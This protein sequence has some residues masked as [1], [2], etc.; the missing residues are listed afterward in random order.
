MHKASTF[1]SNYPFLNLPKCHI[2]K[3]LSLPLIKYEFPSFELGHEPVDIYLAWVPGSGC[4]SQV[5]M[6][7]DSSRGVPK[8]ENVHLH[9]LRNHFI[10]V[11]ISPIGSTCTTLISD[12]RLIHV[13]MDFGLSQKAIPAI[14]ADIYFPLHHICHSM[15]HTLLCL[16]FF[17]MG[18]GVLSVQRLFH[19]GK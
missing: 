4:W 11:A 5:S 12:F 8:P 10:L 19:S 18:Q 15:S 16:N 9:F 17:L 14:P 2:L 3:I 7:I 6:F 1:C 13:H